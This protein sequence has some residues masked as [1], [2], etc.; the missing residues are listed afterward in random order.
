MD[1]LGKPSVVA[2]PPE[3][4]S[5]AGL[6]AED[7]KRLAARLA[8]LRPIPR[9]P[10]PARTL[11]ILAAGGAKLPQ[12]FLALLRKALGAQTRT[13]FLSHGDA[14]RKRSGRPVDH[15]ETT[16]WLNALESMGPVL[17]LAA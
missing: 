8:R 15:P 10:A 3:P 4:L 9:T 17:V 14:V 6:D 5:L 12:R 11:A 16:G 1:I 7:L 2:P 13:L